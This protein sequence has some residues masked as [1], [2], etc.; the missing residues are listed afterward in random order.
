MNSKLIRDEVDGFTCDDQV[1]N[2]DIP[3]SKRRGEAIEV[4]TSTRT[5]LDVRQRDIDMVGENKHVVD[6]VSGLDEVP[7]EPLEERPVQGAEHGLWRI[8]AREDLDED[9]G[10]SKLGD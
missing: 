4:F 3:Y 10:E 2:Q 1:L 5:H 7:K 8:E 6:G 9:I